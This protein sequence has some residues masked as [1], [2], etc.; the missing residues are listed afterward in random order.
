[1]EIDFIDITGMDGKA[2]LVLDFARKAFLE[3]IRNHV[4]EELYIIIPPKC[5]IE[6][7]VF[8]LENV[9]LNIY[10]VSI[11][12]NKFHYILGNNVIKELPTFTDFVIMDPVCYLYEC[13]RLND[14]IQDIK[15]KVINE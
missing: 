12:K 10:G 6:N 5:D 14:I 7:Y 15:G 13:N 2:H 3:Y 4:E 1:M 8:S 11:I 9:M